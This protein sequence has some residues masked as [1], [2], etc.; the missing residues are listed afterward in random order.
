MKTSY[1]YLYNSRVTQERD[2][3]HLKNVSQVNNN[4]KIFYFKIKN[5]QDEP[6]HHSDA[7]NYRKKGNRST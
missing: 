2:P 1:V 4:N 5:K 6:I 7:P 3:H